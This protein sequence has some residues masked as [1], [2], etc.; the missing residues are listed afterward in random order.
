VTPASGKPGDDAPKPDASR[1]RRRIERR[2]RGRL[3]GRWATRGPWAPATRHALDELPVDARR[4]FE[5]LPG[6]FCVL[7]KLSDDSWAL[8][9]RTGISSD[10]LVGLWTAERVLIDSDER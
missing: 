1:F 2:K 9:A 10:A 7:R 4:S 8:V 3:G 5:A 6:V